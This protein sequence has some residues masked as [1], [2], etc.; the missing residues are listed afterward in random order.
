MLVGAGKRGP[1]VVRKIGSPD[2]ARD[3]IEALMLDRGLRRSFPRRVE[4]RPPTPRS[5]STPSART[6]ATWPRSPSIPTT[7]RTSTTRSPPSGTRR[8]A[9]GCGCTSPTC[10]PTCAPAARSTPRPTAAAPAPTCPARWSRCCP[11]R[12][13]TAPAR[14]AR[15][16]TSW[17]SPWRWTW[18]APT[19]AGCE[20]KRSLIRSDVR[21]TYG[22][23][24]E[25]FAGAKQAEDPGASRWRPRGRWR[26]RWRARRQERGALEVNST[27]PSFEFDPEGHVTGVR[28]EAADRVAHADRGADDPRQ[29]AGG[30]LPGRPQAA[31]ALPRAR[32]ARPAGGETWWPSSPRSTS[33]RPRCRR[34]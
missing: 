33:P 29:R 6:C 2:V 18:P 15:G 7:P 16:R 20:F 3:V 9:S 10:P 25:V 14:C 13:P 23:V 30:R 22:E 11:R 5:R 8:A 21:L 32:E 31:H 24:D 17:R 26:P 27:E 12:S 1:R 34:T 19:S 4:R 28:Y